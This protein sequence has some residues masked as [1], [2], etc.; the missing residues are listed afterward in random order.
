[1][2][3]ETTAR[4]IDE[5]LEEAIG[6][7]DEAREELLGKN[8][9]IGVGYGP[10]ERG[11]EIVEDEVAIV[12][13]VVEKKDRDVLDPDD[14]VPPTFGRLPT[15]VVAIGRRTTARPA[16]CAKRCSTSAPTPS[17]RTLSTIRSSTRLLR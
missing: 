4:A 5:R 16:R 1:M 14:V 11:G 15:D 10:K 6:C 2:T 9:V 12:V 17:S 13:Y 8:G 7:L 3:T